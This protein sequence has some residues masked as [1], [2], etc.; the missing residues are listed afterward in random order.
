MLAPA[1]QNQG[2]VMASPEPSYEV[3]S[4]RASSEGLRASGQGLRAGL[5]GPR[6]SGQGLRASLTGLDNDSRETDAH[7]QASSDSDLD[8]SCLVD[9]TPFKIN[10]V[11]TCSLSDAVF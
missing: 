7:V 2:L 3:K 9:N 10:E 6:A 5:Q 8:I 11:C 1:D 4:S